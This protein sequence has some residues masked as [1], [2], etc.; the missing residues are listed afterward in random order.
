MDGA[1]K[2]S[3]PWKNERSKKVMLGRMC[4]YSARLGPDAE[5]LV[6][7]EVTTFQGA[8]KPGSATGH[9]RSHGLQSKFNLNLL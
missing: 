6:L 4:F 1:W 2:L 7:G 5:L 8:V 3:L 9:L